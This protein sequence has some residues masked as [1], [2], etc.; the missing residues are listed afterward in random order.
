MD[1]WIARKALVFT[2][3]YDYL[4][5]THGPDPEAERLAMA[6]TRQSG[7]Q[8]SIASCEFLLASPAE[9]RP[10]GS[11]SVALLLLSRP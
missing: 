1:L 8:G 2:G 7:I 11:L 10:F 9:G 4:K 3:G 6:K 5:N